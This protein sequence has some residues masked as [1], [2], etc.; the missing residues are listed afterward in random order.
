MRRFWVFVGALLIIISFVLSPVCLASPAVSGEKEAIKKL[1]KKYR[2]WLE[3]VTYIITKKEREAFLSLKSD[4]MRDKFIELFWKMRDPT[5]GTKKNEFKEEFYKRFEYANKFLGRETYKPGWKTDRGRIYIL[6][7]PPRDIQRFDNTQYTYPIEL[8][9]YDS[10]GLPGLPAFFHLIFFKRN[11]VGEFVLYDPMR[12]GV[13]ELLLPSMTLDRGLGVAYQLL[14][15]VSPELARAALSLDDGEP[16][17]FY[18]LHPSLASTVLLG[19]I[20]TLPER[21]IHSD[22]VDNFLKGIP[23]VRVEYSYRLITLSS[24]LNT[25]RD[26]LGNYFLHFALGVEPKNVSLGK[27]KDK[28]YGAFEIVGDIS[29]LNGKIIAKINDEVELNLSEEEFKKVRSSS[30]VFEGKKV[31]LPGRYRVKLYLRNNVS[32][33]YGVVEGTI[34][35]PEPSS[36]L[37][38]VS[39]PLLAFKVLKPNRRYSDKRK[40]FEVGNFLFLANPISLF[41]Q[42]SKLYLFYQVYLPR[43]GSISPYSLSARYDILQQKKLISSEEEFLGSYYS[44]KEKVF[45]IVKPIPLSFPPGEYQLKVVVISGG[46]EIAETK[47]ISFTISPYPKL[48]APYIYA[49][50]FPPGFSSLYNYQRGKEYLALGKREEAEREFREA[51]KKNGDFVA[52]RKELVQLYLD[53]KKYKEVIDLLEPVVLKSPNDYEILMA[54]GLSYRGLGEYYDAIRYYE[55]ARMVKGRDAPVGLLNQLGE[56]YQKS[57]NLKKAKEIFELSLKKKANQPLITKKLEE[58]KKKLNSG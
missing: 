14:R 15:Q 17:D 30:F 12:D 20:A 2:K 4:K 49:K 6:L 1:P 25:F 43:E 11:G 26:E 54:L 38:Q 46:K 27:Y 19:K 8:W 33:E 44:G 39:T 53:G 40:P 50:D 37:V 32:R 55:R 24:S 48:P 10:G 3:E 36:D 22:Y 34:D 21:L 45:N 5:P 57:G 51:L 52:A 16:V 31:I 13:E 58:I 28:Y 9:H 41:P 29:D 23:T 42:G 47:P 56:V 7:G 35:V 18:S